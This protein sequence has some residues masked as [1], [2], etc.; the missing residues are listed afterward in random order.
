MWNIIPYV[1]TFELLLSLLIFFRQRQKH[2]QFFIINYIN[3]V[4][5]R[6]RDYNLKHKSDNHLKHN[7]A[8]NIYIFRLLPISLRSFGF[9][10]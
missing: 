6:S 10:V 8:I 5:M 3:T 4:Y 7:R 2:D 1:Q 9:G